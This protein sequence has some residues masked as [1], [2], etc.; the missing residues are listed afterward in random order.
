MRCL[1]DKTF[2]VWTSPQ[3]NNEAS[4][5]LPPIYSELVRLNR[6]RD[7]RESGMSSLAPSTWMNEQ[8]TRWAHTPESHRSDREKV[9]DQWSPR[10]TDTDTQCRFWSLAPVILPHGPAMSA[11]GQG[12]MRAVWPPGGSHLSGSVAQ[13][14][15]SVG[16]MGRRG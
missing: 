11:L 13:R 15:P 16:E 14:V 6:I 2:E 7:S 3:W 8:L 9:D 12:A 10:D 4:W 5:G 1:G